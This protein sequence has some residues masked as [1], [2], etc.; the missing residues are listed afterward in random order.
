MEAA[1]VPVHDFTDADW[2]TRFL[3]N[4]YQDLSEHAKKKY[5]LLQ[6]PE[7]VEEF[8][9]GLTLDKAINEFGLDPEPPEACPEELNLPRGLRVIDPTCG[10]GHFLLGAFHH[11]FE[12]WQAQAPGVDKWDLIHRTLYSVHGVDKNPFA[13]LIAR[14]RLAIAAMKTGGV[15]KFSDAPEFIINIAVG[16]SLIHGRGGPNQD[17]GY[18]DI[19]GAGELLEIDPVFTYDTEDVS[20]YIKTVDILGINSYHVVVG[21]PPYITVKDKIE[22]SNYRYYQ[23]AS[24]SYALSVPFTERFFQLAIRAGRDRR[25][26]GYVGQITANSFMKREFGKKLIEEFF[27]TIRLTHVIDT[28]GAY[29]PGHGTPTVILIG[30]RVYRR[31]EPIRAVLGIRGEPS[32]PNDPAHGF[33]WRALVAQTSTPGSEST[34]FSVTDLPPGA[35]TKHPWSLTG[36]GASALTSML[37]AGQ[38]TSVKERVRLIGRTAHTGSDEA[39]FAPPGAWQRR[40]V[41]EEHVV[42]LVEGEMVRDW[43]LDHSTEALFPYDSRLIAT[44]KDA[45]TAQHLWMHRTALRERREPGGT[46][47]EIGL[48]WYEWSRWHPERFGIHLGIAMAFVATHPHFSM[49]RGGKV[50]K[51]STPVIKLQDNASETEYIEMTGVLNSSTA[52]FWL[53]QVSQPKGGSGIGRGIQDE[54]WENRHEFTST[55][56][57][58]FPLPFRFPTGIARN[59][60]NLALEIATVTPSK[61]CLKGAPETNVLDKAHGQWA[62][63]RAKMIGL[64]EEL[65]W[66]VYQLYGLLTEEEAA[67]LVADPGSVP[68][69]KLGERAFEIMLARKVSA[70]EAETQWF[71]RHGSTPITKVPEHWPESYRRVVEKRIET[72][73]RRP[74]TIG[75]IERPEYKRRWA[76]DPWEKKEKDAL[77][78]WLLDRCEAHELWFAPDHSGHEQPRMMT[79]GRLT[80]RLQ[81]D[82]DFVSVARLY[83]GDDVALIDVLTEILDTG[84]VPFI[85]ALRYKDSGLRKRAQWEETWRLQRQED[86]DGERLDIKVPPKYTSAD[87]VKNSYWRNRGKLD[88]PKERF[89]SY[90]GASPDGDKTLLIGWAGWNH[91]EQAHAL[92]T[93]IEERTTE[94]GWELERLMP[95]LAGLDEVLPWVKQ[96][97]SEVDPMTGLSPAVAYE[98]YLQ[99]QVERYPGLSREELAQWRPPKKAAKKKAAK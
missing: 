31:D 83:A 99:Q 56:L 80:D 98:G 95:L 58:E 93:L 62:S 76:T 92:V 88:V 48:T 39:Y 77:R 74:Q 51:Q 8:I 2:N 86:E 70:G 81:D 85:P 27:P 67:D 82:V 75:L 4:L 59:L 57:K 25:R 1:T 15:D 35:L 90:P 46:H 23:S 16:D 18:M 78:D 7:F 41:A 19:S 32:Q 10:S 55:K 68:G 44:I 69:V 60:D 17:Q 14:F 26:S 28:S 52:C 89:I 29:I 42:P 3:G 50:F 13:V 61:L 84:H 96:W 45:V 20:D 6:T 21:N 38:Y 54:A 47:E 9:L 66:E 64:Q 79:V 43:F 11:I 24:G 97:H 94:D 12:R 49:E 71:A 72:I 73:E 65:D 87:F 34:W 30:R 91:A 5:A 53:K 40:G 22:K 33:V 37:E 63:I 36:G